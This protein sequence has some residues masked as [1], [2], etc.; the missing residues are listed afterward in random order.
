M[1]GDLTVTQLL[2]GLA[3]AAY[4]QLGNL[5]ILRRKSALRAACK[6]DEPIL[7]V[8]RKPSVLSSSTEEQYSAAG[9]APVAPE[10]V[11]PTP[12]R[13]SPRRLLPKIP[14]VFVHKGE[15]QKSLDH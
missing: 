1:E 2:S 11:S 10:V 8:L 14:R 15:R 12:G 13:L 9:V 5:R 7:D 3:C 4:K 6:A